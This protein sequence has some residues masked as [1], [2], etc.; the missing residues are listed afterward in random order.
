MNNLFIN[1][2]YNNIF[3][4]K[5]SIGTTNDQFQKK[6]YDACINN[7][8]LL[9]KSLLVNFKNKKIK[10]I[11]N[12]IKQCCLKNNLDIINWFISEDIPFDNHHD[13]FVTC[14][15]NGFVD[16]AK[17]IYDD[18]KTKNVKIYLN[19]DNDNIFRSVCSGGLYQMAI[20]LYHLSKTDD[21][22][23]ININSSNNS[24]F[25]NSCKNGKKEIAEWLFELS[26]E[27][28]NEDIDLSCLN[29]SFEAS[30]Y[31]GHLDIMKWLYA[32]SDDEQFKYHIMN[33]DD[34]FRNCCWYYRKL[35]VIDWFCE[36]NSRYSYK[37]INNQINPIVK[38]I[39]T[40]LKEIINDHN[41]LEIYYDKTNLKQTVDICPICLSEDEK[42]F[43][44]MSCNH[45]MCAGC[46]C[47]YNNSRCYYNCSK[48]EIK[49]V[50]LV[51]A[52]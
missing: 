43:V 9:V 47:C 27:D 1:I 6:F 35:Y 29:R 33:T 4:L 20:Y 32:L 14:C 51:K 50:K 49:N 7:D 15:H 12:I 52:A 31:E 25:F 17:I 26:K 48:G 24:S 40:I 2:Y 8:L 16:L 28:D 41:K 37:V 5:M 21:N 23:K 10:K 34:I 39:K 36:V 45:V 3:R 42:Y 19:Y 22:Q 18:S 13:L 38:E 30:C 44:K 11:N 46:Y